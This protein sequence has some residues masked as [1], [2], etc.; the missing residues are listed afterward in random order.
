[1]LHGLICLANTECHSIWMVLYIQGLTECPPSSLSSPLPS[2][3][4]PPSPPP[5]PLSSSL[6]SSLLP[7]LLPP[8]RPLQV[9]ML[10]YDISWAAFNIVEVMSSTKF[11]F[12]VSLSYC[13][14]P[15]PIL[16]CSHIPIPVIIP[17]IRTI[18]QRFNDYTRFQFSSSTIPL[19]PPPFPPS[20]F[21]S[22]SLSLLLLLPLPPPP[23]PL[24]PTS[25]VATWLPPSLSTRVLT[26]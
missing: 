10:G 8:L 15:I 20:P 24:S 14:F 22:F 6:P 17:K 13:Q 21:P 2:P 12:K 18:L 26:L 7:P 25:E 23:T 11:T 5:S 19:F 3:S 1:M 4:P 9:Q 16:P